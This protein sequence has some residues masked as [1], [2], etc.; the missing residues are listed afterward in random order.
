TRKAARLS[1]ILCSVAFLAV[2]PCLAG[3]GDRGAPVP[4]AASPMLVDWF[5]PADLVGV[6][7]PL[8]RSS[9]YPYA[10]ALKKDGT[11]V[12]ACG[13]SVLAL[14]RLWRVTGL[15]AKRLSDE[16]NYNFAYS[17]AMTAA[18]TMYLRS[19]DGANMWA[20]ADGSPDYRRVRAEGMPGIAFGVLD[21]GTPFVAE[22]RALRVYRDGRELRVELPEGSSALAASAGPDNTIWLADAA[23]GLVSVLS[24]EGRPLR[25]V[26]LDLRPGQAVMKLRVLPDGGMLAAT[27]D[28]VR[29]FDPEGRT[30]WAWNGVADG[31]SMSFSTYT[32]IALAEGGIV[33]VNDLMGKRV[34][35]LA[36]RPDGLPPDLAAIAAAGRAMRLSENG[37]EAALALAGAYEAAGSDEAA[38]ATLE[39]YLDERP[40]DSAAIARRQR[41][42]AELLKAKA[43]S[44]QAD[45]T[46]LLGRF[47]AETARDAYGRAMRTWESLR[48]GSGDDEEIRASMA[49]L[50]AA[51]Q[52]A[53]RGTEAEAPSP[54]VV[55]TE[56]AA[57]FPSLLRSYLTEPAGFIVV[58]NTLSDTIRDVRA[59][60]F[61]KKYMDFPSEGPRAATIA[62]GRQARLDL[63]A[64]LNEE[65]LEVQE[66]IP[67]QALV[68]VR[69]SDA[70]GERSFELS[71]PVT[72]Y[73]RTAITWDDSG[74]LA[75]FVT[76]NEGS[77]AGMA[78]ELI[79]S[80]GAREPISRT[81][82]RAAAICDAL[83]ALPLSYVP[84]PQSPIAQALGAKGSLDTVRFPRTTL[85]YKGG[86]CDDTTALLAS[87]LEAV[88][89][90]AAIMTS[91][92]HVFLAFDTGEPAGNAWL[93]DSPGLGA[94][95]RNGSLWIPVETTALSEGFIAAWRAASELVARHSGGPGLEFLPIAGLRS[96][97]PPLPLP[98]STLP[99]PAPDAARLSALASAFAASVDGD[100]YR[101]RATALEAERARLSGSAAARAGNRLA[102]LHFRHGRDGLAQAVL[103]EVVGSNQAFVPGWLNLA[104]LA[105]AAGREDEASA[106]LR[107]AQAASPGSSAVRSWAAAAGLSGE[108]GFGP[109]LA[110]TETGGG[111]SAPRAAERGLPAWAD[112]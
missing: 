80:R 46:G 104:A 41:L 103:A 77:V 83:G 96:R 47:G 54:R 72:L 23:T 60:L 34:I 79:K 37:P 57:L 33:Y 7:L 45:A 15:P 32:D 99:L 98:P 64:S 58:E 12:V 55:E 28:E 106:Y 111:G 86:D 81:F 78:F 39:R 65:A 36:E 75:A 110:D 61:I 22:A 100:L 94:I 87:M 82:S 35:R 112:E 3:P 16:G 67:L 13:T 69:Y 90:P 43:R 89:I 108:L 85:A 84:D 14:D 56:I 9:L 95:E 38:R 11:L 66:D 62:P 2:E 88:G 40:A 76:P 52:A 30:V 107:R 91:P 20:F 26:K 105:L 74:K 44:A 31:I 93:F 59:D 63:F 53:E 71:R 1:A 29:R 50:R 19:T 70:R 92:G 8:G 97:Y 27:F 4:A 49:S 18:D 17:M 68:T 109:E 6:D 102:Q 42:E 21:D 101:A 24:A 73:R 51:F 48:A 5:S 25:S 10:L